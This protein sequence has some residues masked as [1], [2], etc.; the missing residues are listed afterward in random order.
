MPRFSSRLLAAGALSMTVLLAAGP[1][2]AQKLDGG[3]FHDGGTFTNE[4]F[5]G[6]AG[7]VVDGSYKNDGRFLTRLQGP[8]KVFYYME[9]VRSVTVFTRRATGQTVT[10]IQPSTINKDLKITVN[11]DGTITIISLLTGGD[12]LYGAGGRL[13]ASNSGQVRF[14]TVIDYN[15]TL[16]NPDDDT[17]VSASEGPIFGSTGTNDDFCTAVLAD[18]GVTA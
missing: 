16:S 11:D 12:R 5:C 17:F 13:I 8:D 10:D 3:T 18:W 14:R 1:A 4:N 7:L 15:G 9:H 2:S 6:V